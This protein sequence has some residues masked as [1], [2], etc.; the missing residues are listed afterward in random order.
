MGTDDNGRR[1]GDTVTIRVEKDQLV[2]QDNHPPDASLGAETP[3]A[4]KKHLEE[5]DEDVD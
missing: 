2:I 3:A 5:L 4:A 1:D